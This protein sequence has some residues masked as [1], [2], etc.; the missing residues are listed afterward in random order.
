MKKLCIVKCIMV[1]VCV[2]AAALLFGYAVMSLWNALLPALFGIPKI[3]LW[4]AF[5]IFLLSKILF[6]GFHFGR[7]GCGC[8]KDGWKRGMFRKQWEAKLASLSPEER[9][10]MKK[11]FFNRCRE[12]G[13]ESES[14]EKGMGE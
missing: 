10:K 12:W 13:H 11:S 14:K 5:G 8:S 4:Q 1:V 7:K 9:E 6:S 2:A 3:D